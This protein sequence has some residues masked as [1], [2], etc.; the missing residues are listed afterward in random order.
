MKFGPLRLEEAEGAML[1]HAT[2]AGGERLK[3]AHRLTGADIARLR[4]A[5]LETVIVA[6]LEAGDVDEDAAAARVADALALDGIEI[7][8]PATGRVNLHAEYAGVF[9]LSRAAIDAI[10]RV[11]QAVTIA[12]LAPFASV[13]AG[14]MVATIKI[15]PF[16]VPGSVLDVVCAHAASAAPMRVAPFRARKVALIQTTLPAV[17]E[18]VLDKTA[19]ITADRLARSGGTIMRERRVAHDERALAAEIAE[20][21]G[22]ADLVIVF[23]ASALC[24]GDDVI[25]AAIKLAGGHVERVGMPV[26]PGNLLVLGAASGTRLIGAPGCARSP[27][28]NGFDWVLDRLM[29]GVDVTGED[30]AAMGV[31][32]LVMEIPSRPQPRERRPAAR[33]APKVAALLLAA[34]RSQRMGATNK[35]LATFE[36]KPLVRR[37]AAAAAASG[38]SRTIAV[39]GHETEKVAAALDGLGIETVVNPAYAEGL[40]TSLKAG[41]A[42]LPGD[43]EGVLVMLGDMPGV[44]TAQI[45][46]ML[47]RF[48]REGGGCVVRATHAGKRGNPVLLP[49]ALF[50]DLARIDGDVGA[51]Q[52]VEMTGLPVH[53]VEIG[54]A[55]SLDVDTPQELS[56]AGGIAEPGR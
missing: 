10:N 51:R 6:R 30:I 42:A 1:A 23:G 54:A 20:A 38:V 36:G 17:K 47:A 34:G 2:N 12:T 43:V 50:A 53:D 4:A 8:P 45:E 29:A 44:G 16:A 3:K 22:A 27:K 9:T 19:R 41:V 15:I 55:A 13:T 39:L 31:G 49:R 25:P 35:L 33:R 7:R 56:A 18:S 14:Q 24:D 5:G 46:L 11:D 32:G 37:V 40:A 21:S 48:A 28:D 52:I 26:D